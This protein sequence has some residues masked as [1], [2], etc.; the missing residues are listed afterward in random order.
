M[1]VRRALVA[2]VLSAVTAARADVLTGEEHLASFFAELRALKGG[3]AKRDAIVTVWGDSHTAADGWTSVVRGE[4]QGRFGSGGRGFVTL[5]KPWKSHGQKQVTFTN[6]AG[7]EGRSIL[8]KEPDLAGAYGLGGAYVL[9][10]GKRAAVTTT[11]KEQVDAVAIQ[12]GGDADAGTV[13]LLLDGSFGGS[14]NLHTT[15]PSLVSWVVHVPP[16]TR[17][18]MVRSRDGK[19]FR[20]YGI[21]GHRHETGVV[22]DAL[23]L[24]GSR[25]ENLERIDELHLLQAV[26]RRKPSLVVFAYGTNEA[27]DDGDLTA[28]AERMTRTL[29]KLRRGQPAAAC[30]LVGPPD[31]AERVGDHWETMARVLSIAEMQRRVARASGCA[32]FDTLAAI[33]GPGTVEDWSH[34]DPPRAQRDHVHYTWGGYTIWGQ[35]LADAL[36]GAYDRF[37]RR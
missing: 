19:P 27:G 21:S 9:C 15:T 26:A 1:T 28:Y 29:E 35:A 25:A 36:L 4:L 34:E 32:F 33:G 11:F 8:D 37:A 23:G 22:V 7:C 6:S 2:A 14:R 17:E 31:R 10:R 3:T 12:L 20:A 16:T 13:D 5:G 18:F 30:L 24:N